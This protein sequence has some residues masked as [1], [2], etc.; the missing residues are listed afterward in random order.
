MEEDSSLR[1]R[2]FGRMRRTI[3]DLQEGIVVPEAVKVDV[4][5]ALGLVG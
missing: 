4:R 1:W 3:Y 2:E 5:W